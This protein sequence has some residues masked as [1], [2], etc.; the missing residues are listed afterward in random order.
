MIST[1]G[2]TFADRGNR[3]T[4]EQAGVAVWLDTAFELCLE[5]CRHEIGTRPMFRDEETLESLY[6]SRRDEYAAAKIAVE[7][8]GRNSELVADDVVERLEDAIW[9]SD[10]FR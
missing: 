5:H 8:L 10:S 4:I 2:G 3:R 6:E 9:S 7:T 1:G